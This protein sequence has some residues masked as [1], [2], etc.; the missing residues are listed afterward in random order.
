MTSAIQ[1][2]L[3][4]AI[5]AVLIVIAGVVVHANRRANVQIKPDAA[6]EQ[7]TNKKMAPSKKPYVM[8]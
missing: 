6:L 2:K 4:A 8:P 1:I 3:L 7:Q 5:L